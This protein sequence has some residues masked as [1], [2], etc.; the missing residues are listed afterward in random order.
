MTALPSQ[1]E[2]KDLL[3]RQD[4]L[5]AQ[6]AAHKDLTT[7]LNG[8]LEARKAGNDK[9]ELPVE[10][11]PGFT[12][13]GVVQDTSRIILAAGIDDL[14]LELPIERAQP[15]VQKRIDILERRSKDLEKPIARLK[16][17]YALVAKTLRDAFQLPDDL[18]SAAI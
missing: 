7:R 6:L 3:A 9:M 16:E 11:G 14:W 5:E 2:L 18:A 10:L 15:F 8:L 13:E 12:V 1:V 4:A 17:E